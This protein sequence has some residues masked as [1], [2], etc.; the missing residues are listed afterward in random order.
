MDE[1]LLTVLTEINNRLS[2]IAITLQVM[3]LMNASVDKREEC[4]KFLCE[5]L[6]VQKCKYVMNKAPSFPYNPL[7]GRYDA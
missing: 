5:F 2:D 3:S 1:K 6:E 4:Y 7:T